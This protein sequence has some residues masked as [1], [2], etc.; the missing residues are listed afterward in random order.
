MEHAKLKN[1][2]KPYPTQT[3]YTMKFI[4]LNFDKADH[5]IKLLLYF[6]KQ[7]NNN[8]NNKGY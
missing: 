6:D 5:A 1:T 4:M 3:K 8:N 7:N 2:P